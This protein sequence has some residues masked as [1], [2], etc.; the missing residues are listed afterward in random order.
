MEDVD[1]VTCPLIDVFGAKTR[2]TTRNPH[3]E[4]KGFDWRLQRVDFERSP[5]DKSALE[6]PYA[7]VL[8]TFACEA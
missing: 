7:Y 6:L 3:G 8:Y 4:R 1:A 2:L 5:G